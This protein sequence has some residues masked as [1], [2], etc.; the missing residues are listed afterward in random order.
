MA[1]SPRNSGKPSP[2][3]RWLPVGAEV[4]PRGGVHFRV[5]APRC[6]SVK[7]QVNSRDGETRQPIALAGE[8]DGY[9]SIFDP[10]SRAGDCYWLLLDEDSSRI[11]DPAS[12][13][14]PEGPHGPS[15]II[16][17]GGY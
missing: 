13:F 5:W 9:H 1:G 17:P 15:E 10:A 14:Q 16:D 6:H 8:E 2:Y 4:Q 3:V 12:R 7:V 11:P